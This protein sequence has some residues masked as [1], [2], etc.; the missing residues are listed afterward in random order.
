MMKTT[1]YSMRLNPDVKANAEKTFAEFGL[2]LSE[3]IN[4]FL[5]MAIKRRGFPFEIINHA[6][7]EM[8]LASFAEADALLMNPD[9][10]GYAS[11][12]ELN[13]ALDAE[14]AGDSGDV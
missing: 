7:N 4:V 9:I 14:D 11:V 13:A 6:P 5:H 8:L 3:A 10:K 2:N 1:N 12:E